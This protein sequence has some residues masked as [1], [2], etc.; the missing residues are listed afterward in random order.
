MGADTTLVPARAAE[1]E[2]F[3][4]IE[5][6]FAMVMLNIGILALVAAFQGGTASLA[7]SS[8]KAN[9]AVVADKM[10]ELYRGFTSCAIY[11]HVP[12]G[13][14]GDTTDASNRTVPNGIPASGSSTWYQQYYTDGYSAWS[15]G[16]NPYFGYLPA[17]TP[18]QTNWVTDYPNTSDPTGKGTCSVT[19]PAGSPSMNTPVQYVTGPD[20]AQ[21]LVFTYIVDV[22][23]AGSGWIKQVTI[24]VFSPLNTA[25]MIASETAYFD[26]DVTG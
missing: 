8:L 21:Y 17:A 10:M 14:G 11:L 13:G 2:G 23:P 22:E 25:Q 16:G 26:P 7:R 24:D 20:G 5:L 15:A 6:V 3:G 1:E 9:G 19:L 18:P 12:T 4:L